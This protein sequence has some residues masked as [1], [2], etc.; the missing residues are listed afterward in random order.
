MERTVDVIATHS[1]IATFK[2]KSVKVSLGFKP[3]SSTI[4][5]F[6]LMNI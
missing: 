3:V 2:N 1:T 5:E 4:T 6:K